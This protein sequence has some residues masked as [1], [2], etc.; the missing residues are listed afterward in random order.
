MA[1]L[2]RQNMH[3]LQVPSHADEIPF[4]ADGFHPSKQELSEAHN[5]LDD[6]EDRFDSALSFGIDCPTVFCLQSMLHLSDSINI[7]R[8]RWRLGKALF[9]ILV[10][11]ITMAADVWKYLVSKAAINV[12]F[13]EVAG[14]CQ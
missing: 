8:Q 14:I 9:E 2:S 11:P 12:V 13:A 6:A 5:S 10:V 7:L 1:I 4:P 3:S